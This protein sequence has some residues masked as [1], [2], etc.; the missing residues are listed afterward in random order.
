MRN[1]ILAVLIISFPT[2]SFSQCTTGNCEDGYGEKNYDGDKY[3]G[4]FSNS[5][6]NGKGTYTWSDGAKYEGEWKDGQYH[7]Y[8]VLKSAT[9]S[10][11][12]GEYRYDK[13]HGLGTQYSSN[14]DVTFAGQYNE[15]QKQVITSALSSDVLAD[16]YLL[17]A[18]KLMDAGSY[19]EAIVSFNRILALKVSPPVTF[20]Y[21][22]G[23]CFYKA[24]NYNRA[25]SALTKYLSLAGKNSEYYIVSLELL[26]DAE[27]KT[28]TTTQSFS[29]KKMEIR[30]CSVCSGSGY[31]YKKVTCRSCSGR[32]QFYENCSDCAGSGR[33]SMRCTYCGGT[34]TVSTNVGYGVYSSQGCSYC[35]SGWLQCYKCRG[36]GGYYSACNACNGSG[37]TNDKTKCYQH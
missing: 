16:K 15:G 3:Q 37:T 31:Y 13:K 5:K 18:K 4:Y 21:F 14:G 8:G 28:N 24:A 6:K 19:K 23:K 20:Y 9:G 22:L 17:E 26:S 2:I 27:S 30:N 1:F 7:G 11:Y 35:T 12:E 10:C 34:G 33:S 25:T 36:N 29:E 32:R